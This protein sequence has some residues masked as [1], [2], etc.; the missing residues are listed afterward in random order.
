M[1]SIDKLIQGWIDAEVEGRGEKVI[2]R[3]N[4][5]KTMYTKDDVDII[6]RGVMLRQ[7]ND[8]LN[9]SMILSMKR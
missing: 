2:T 1:E 4:T 9:R 3:T 8:R 5:E 6:V 7:A